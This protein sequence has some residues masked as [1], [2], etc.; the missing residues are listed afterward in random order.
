MLR[1][2]QIAQ[3]K[4][5]LAY[6]DSGE[7]SMAVS[8]YRNSVSTYVSQEQ[9][10]AEQDVFFRGRPQFV[11]LSCLLP[12]PGDFL[13]H[14][15]TGVPALLVRDK[16]GRLQAFMNVCRHRGAKVE[17]AARGSGKRVFTCPYH[18]WSYSRRGELVGRPREAAFAEADREHHGLIALPVAERHG[19]IWMCA[20]PGTEIDVDACLE[21]LVDDMKAYDLDS[22][23]HFE[24]RTLKRRMNWKLVIDTFL[25]GYH[26][27]VLHKKTIAP[28]IHPDLVAFD[29]FGLN[30][31]MIAPRKTIS[32]L[33]ELPETEWD[34]IRHTGVVCI[35]FPNVVFV[36]QG[37]HLET[38]H[39]YPSGNGVD[40]CEMYISLY[41]P[42]PATT[43]SARRHWLNNFDLLM[44]TVEQ[45]DFPI[46][47]AMHKGFYSGAQ[48]SVVHGRNEPAIAHYHQSVRAAL[49]H[50]AAA[51]T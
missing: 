33:R 41:T 39:V 3:A 1:E 24:T 20:T 48:E 8:I 25:E 19:M 35:L 16:D 12:E 7:T 2:E 44:R 34:L 27:G 6:L 22:Y 45:E 23:A 14:D 15:Y 9:A 13:T 49:G 18:A 37:D 21:G 5:L 28:I 32:E 30:L 36:M 50:R 10:K 4:R 47:E 43:D 29:P 11:G 40:E 51:L 26:I 42:E 17:R 31:R 46:A 38:W